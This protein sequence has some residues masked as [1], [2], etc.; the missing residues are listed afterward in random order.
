MFKTNIAGRTVLLK[1][2]HD[3]SFLEDFGHIFAV[4]DSLISGNICF[5]AQKN[6][7][8]YFLKYAG[9]NTLNYIGSAERAV[10]RLKTAAPLYETLRHKALANLLFTKEYP[11]GFMMAFDYVY[12]FPIGPL[13]VY[14]SQLRSLP[15]KT[16]LY[17]LDAM[18]DFFVLASRNDYIAAN[19]SDSK[20]LFDIKNSALILSSINGFVKM[21]Y[22]NAGRLQG[23]SV[24]LAPESYKI[25]LLDERV[26]V[27]AM[28]ALAMQLLGDIS[29]KS[30]ED[31]QSDK[32]LYCIAM[33]ALSENRTLRQ[34]SAY[35][36]LKSWREAVLNISF[37]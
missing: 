10:Q 6:G 7:K 26:T 1:A 9:A 3:F 37:S 36:F 14:K 30:L 35:S 31:W 29:T 22:H 15:V 17:M 11:D 28:G 2:E 34:E 16:R 23:S 18:F 5:G 8:Y 32:S 13:P 33:Q 24:Y 21:P 4:Y 27:Y 25:A 19:L 12:S 20:F